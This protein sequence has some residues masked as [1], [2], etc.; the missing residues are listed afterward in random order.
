M[1]QMSTIANVGSPVKRM[2][3]MLQLFFKH[4]T[5]YYQRLVWVN[6]VFFLVDHSCLNAVLTMCV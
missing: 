1:E 3:V 2:F 4:T 5:A 6:K